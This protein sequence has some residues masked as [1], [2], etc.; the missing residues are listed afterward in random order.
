MPIELLNRINKVIYFNK[1]DYKCI[2]SIV[3]VKLECV[4]LE[5]ANKNIKLHIS[6]S[7]INKIIKLSRYE[8]Y[9]ARRIEQVI[10]DEI[11]NYVIDSIL[12]G[13][14]EIYIKC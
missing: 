6:N 4:K 3:K 9:G 1:M 5:C 13:N 8:E 11:D 2:Y 14:K 7:I 12:A 10:E